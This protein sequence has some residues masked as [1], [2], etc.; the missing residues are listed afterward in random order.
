M[1]HALSGVAGRNENVLRI[2]RIASDEG[3]IVDRLHN[4]AR[5]VKLNLSDLRKTLARPA[6]EPA[7]PFV[8]VALLA[9][10]MVLAANDQNLMV[11]QALNSQVV[12]RIQRVPI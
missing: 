4:L 3:E 8:A 1:R 11:V 2:E 7:I 10:L 9:R 5:P 6:F 12:I